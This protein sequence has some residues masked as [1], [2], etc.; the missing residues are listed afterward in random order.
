MVWLLTGKFQRPV[1]ARRPTSSPALF[2]W[3]PLESRNDDG[4]SCRFTPCIMRPWTLSVEALTCKAE[5]AQHVEFNCFLSIHLLAKLLGDHAFLFVYPLTHTGS[6]TSGSWALLT[7][8]PCAHTTC[9]AQHTACC[10]K[11]A[12]ICQMLAGSMSPLTQLSGFPNA[13]G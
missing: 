11:F 12:S 4:T 5:S 10:R 13:A 3:R 9:T 8:C 1:G 2:Q 6:P 7:C